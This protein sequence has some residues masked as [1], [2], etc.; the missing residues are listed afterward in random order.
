MISLNTEYHLEHRNLHRSS[1]FQL[2][3]IHGWPNALYDD[4]A[5]L[6]PGQDRPD[7]NGRKTRGYCTHASELFPTWHRAYLL[8]LEK[9]RLTVLGRE[10]ES[11]PR[12]LLTD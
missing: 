12:A 11:P 8:A 9:V 7:T 10:H 6:I 4:V 3:G 1:F 2:G 5:P